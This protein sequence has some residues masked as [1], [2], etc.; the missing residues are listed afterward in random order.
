MAEWLC[1]NGLQDS[2]LHFSRFTPLYKLN[3]IPP[4]P[5]SA[6]EQARAIA[7]KAGLH[8]VY[9]GNVP[10]H[11]AENTFCPRCGGIAVER[12]GYT[13]MKMEIAGGKC[14][15]CGEKIP[16]VWA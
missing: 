4:T 1:A 15:A 11:N 16:G 5:V 12:L 3:Q 6:L 13:V 10:G 14:K 9:I 8:Y 7:I 2:P